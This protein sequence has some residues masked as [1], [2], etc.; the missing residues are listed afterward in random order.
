MRRCWP[1]ILITAGLFLVVGGFIYDLEF[2][3]F[4]YQDPTPEMSARYAH[5]AHIASMIRWFG[6]G[7]FLLGVM[8][9]IIRLI[10]ERFRPRGVS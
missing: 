4:P 8:A 3:G 5:H 7:V 10:V 2:A 6:L 1:H 9:G